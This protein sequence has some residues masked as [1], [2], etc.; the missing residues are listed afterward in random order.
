MFHPFKQLCVKHNF[1][2][3]GLIHAGGAGG[4]AGAK[5]M[6]E[7][8]MQLP[9]DRVLYIDALPF[10]SGEKVEDRLSLIALLSDSVQTKEFHARGLLSSFYPVN[11]SVLQR[12]MPELQPQVQEQPYQTLSLRTITLDEML[13]AEAKQLFNVL[14]VSVNGAEREVLDGCKEYLRD[15]I[16]FVIVRLYEE[17]LFN[18]PTMTIAD[19]NQYFM[20]YNMFC[21]MGIQ[22]NQLKMSDVLYVKQPYA[23][24][25][26]TDA[27]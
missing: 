24:Q 21:A 18:A 26:A 19:W 14:Y 27:E 6:I 12:L 15:G 2:I 25:I 17:P 13:S 1:P 4:T 3:R 7:T 22:I 16:D 8:S 5:E 23:V 9:P 20:K 10:E 11:E